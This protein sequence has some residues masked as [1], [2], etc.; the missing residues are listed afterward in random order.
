MI[1]ANSD[2]DLRTWI[3]IIFLRTE[4]KYEILNTNFFLIGDRYTHT[5]AIS[6]IAVTYSFANL[7]IR[8][9]IPHILNVHRTRHN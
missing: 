9:A 1:R 7:W 4:M 8:F 2:V 3:R 6:Y 5:F